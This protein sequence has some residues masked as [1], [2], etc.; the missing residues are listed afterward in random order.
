M[1]ELLELSRSNWLA[2]V[3]EA[4][5]PLLRANPVTRAAKAPG[6]NGLATLAKLATGSFESIERELRAE[7]AQL[8]SQTLRYQ[9]AF[10]AIE[11]GVC[12]FDAEERLV[13]L[14]SAG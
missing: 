12:L 13:L 5:R 3:S 14:Y 6:A 7:I 11:Q 9:T 10:D 1:T 2:M 4:E 8:R